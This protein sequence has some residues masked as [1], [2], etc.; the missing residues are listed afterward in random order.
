MSV[1]VLDRLKLQAPIPLWAARIPQQNLVQDAATVTLPPM[2]GYLP[3]GYH[4]SIFI[5]AHLCHTQILLTGWW[6][7]KNKQGSFSGTHPA[8]IKT[9]ADLATKSELLLFCLRF[10]KPPA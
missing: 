9:N 4:L 1:L 6:E 8:C 5:L 10:Y 2:N 3:Y 7:R